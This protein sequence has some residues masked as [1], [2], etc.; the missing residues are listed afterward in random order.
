MDTGLDGI[1]ES[2]RFDTTVCGQF[3][4]LRCAVQ[5]IACTGGHLLYQIGS[6]L[7][8][9]QA[10][11]THL[12]R[13]ERADKD[14][15]TVNFKGHIG[16]DFVG[17]LIIL[18]DDK[19]RLCLI[20][21][22]KTGFRAG[23]YIHSVDLVVLDIATGRGHLAHLIRT[24]LQLIEVHAAAEVGGAGL[25]DTA[26]DMLDL[27]SRTGERSAAVCV[28][29]VHA[30]IAIGCIFKGDGRGIAV[31]HGNSLRGF[32]AQHVP[33]GRRFLRDDILAGKSQRNDDLAAGIRNKAA[34]DSPVRGL[35]LKSRAGKRCV[36]AGFYLLDDER[37]FS[38]RFRF[39]WGIR[40]RSGIPAESG[41]PNLGSRVGVA[42]I[43]LQGAVFAGF[44]AQR[45]VNGIFVDIGVQR[46]LHRAG[47]VAYAVF[48]VQHL[49]LTGIAGPIG[50]GPDLS[51]VVVVR[52]YDAGAIRHFI[53][54]GETD[55]D[56]VIAYPCFRIRREH[57]LQVFFAIHGDGIGGVLVRRYG[58]GRLGNA[59]PPDTVFIDVL[60]SRENFLAALLFCTGQ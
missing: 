24:G 12:V 13:G 50:R 25:G 27:H 29:L 35:Y 60:C 15:I 21:Q 41:L 37:G 1:E 6:R 16:Q 22:H 11:L 43:P 17:L 52:V 7:E 2:Q 18:G 14:G 30:Q 36:R 40:R 20:F 51:D 31:V 54:H 57:L 19:S 9:G 23:G 39:V 59:V 56:V 48:G 49:E 5:H 10:D 33:L 3:D 26:F 46:H 4:L 55:V 44:R 45:I 38:G 47:L 58:D 28:D 53:G 42:H 32:R 8:V 34:E